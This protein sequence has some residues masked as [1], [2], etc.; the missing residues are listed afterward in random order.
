MNW[1]LV[2]MPLAVLFFLLP[3]LFRPGRDERAERES[4]LDTL[5]EQRRNLVAAIRELDFDREMGKLSDA[6]HQAQREAMKE[7]V[8][9]TILRIREEEGKTGA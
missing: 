1:L 8:A 3:P 9:E 6:D 4:L 5:G 2:I 7:Q